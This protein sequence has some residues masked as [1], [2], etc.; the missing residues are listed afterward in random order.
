M[1]RKT[2]VFERNLIADFMISLFIMR[3]NMYCIFITFKRE[4]G[5]AEC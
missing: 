3:I 5:R 1:K 2:Q 4:D